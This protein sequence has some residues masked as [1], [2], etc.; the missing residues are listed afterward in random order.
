MFIMECIPK[1]IC[2]YWIV[3]QNNYIFVGIGV[4]KLN[5]K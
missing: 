3:I 2:F 4:E 1:K 5:N